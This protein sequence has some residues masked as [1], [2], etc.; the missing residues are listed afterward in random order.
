MEDGADV[1]VMQLQARDTKAG[2][3]PPAAE[4]EALPGA[5]RGSDPA[6][7]MSSDLGLQN[8]ARI[9]FCWLKPSGL[10]C[11]VTQP[12]D[13]NPQRVVWNRAPCLLNE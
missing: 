6:D 8:R 12:L 11:S 5:S 9:N 3:Q 7:T 4:R 13:T 1:E 2:Q 10:Q